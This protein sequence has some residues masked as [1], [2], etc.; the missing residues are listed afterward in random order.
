MYMQL[1]EQTIRELKGEDIEDERRAAV[2]LRIDLRVADTYV[3]DMNQR[4]AIYRR[5]ASVTALEA[6][7][8]LVE[9]L[10]DRYGTPPDSV[11]NLAQYARIRLMADRVGLESLDRDGSIVVLK[12]RQ[13]APLDPVRILKLVEGRADLMLLPPAV[14]KLDLS[15]KSTDVVPPPPAHRP[16]AGRLRPGKWTPP[17]G[18]AEPEAAPSWWAARA[19]ADVAPG[20]TREAI[21][22]ESPVDPAAPGGLFDRVGQLLQAVGQAIRV[23]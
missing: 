5:L 23:S 8:A 11:T 6:V 12:F 15:K 20:F 7:D 22:A 4:L 18:P 16:P 1:L 10:R 2:N 17:A 13:D 9:E 21:L 3:P 19:T 14:L